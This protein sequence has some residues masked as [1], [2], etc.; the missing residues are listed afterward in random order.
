VLK[1]YYLPGDDV[2][3]NCAPPIGLTAALHKSV[4]RHYR[5]LNDIRNRGSTFRNQVLEY[6]RFCSKLFWLRV[7]R[8]WA[9]KLSELYQ[10]FQW[11]FGAFK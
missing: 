4:T 7:P 10:E 5:R 1:A 2:R 6:Q 9:I 11:A 8:E 3:A